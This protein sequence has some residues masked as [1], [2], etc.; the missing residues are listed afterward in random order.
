ML[1]SQNELAKILG[2]GQSAIRTLVRMGK[3]PHNDA[4]PADGNAACFSRDRIVEWIRAGP[5]LEANDNDIDKLR[6]S[7]WAAHPGSM[8]A[9]KEFGKR[10]A[11]KK[12]PKLYY[13]FK[14][15]NKK[16]GHMWYVMY[17]DRGKLVPSK[18]STGTSDKKAAEVFAIESREPLLAAYYARKGRKPADMYRL[19]EGYY[20]EGSELL[21]ADANRGRTLCDKRRRQCLN[22]VKKKFVPFIKKNGAR[23]IEDINAAMLNRFQDHLL[24]TLAPKS[25][26][27]HASAVRVMFK[28]L[29]AT[30]YADSNPFAGLPAIKKGEGK[31]TGCYEV[32][33]LK[34]AFGG[35]W[36]NPAHRILC[37]LIYS[38]GM[39]NGEIN[40][41]RL[42][43]LVEIGGETF[44]D[45]PK[46]K[47]PSGERKVPLHPFARER[48]V[49]YAGGRDLVF[50]QVGKTFEKLC[51]A[52]NAALGERLGYTREML[53]A[54]NIRFYSGRHFWKTMMSSENL[55]ESA[56]KLLMG[57]KVSGDI[58]NTYNHLDKV[59]AEK[60][61][62][63]AREAFAVLDRCLFG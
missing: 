56:E 27:D 53:K 49:G 1:L 61:A 15:E 63:V 36:D 18:W 24:K 3:I 43:D 51:S 19:F 48:L 10:F 17:S 28:R 55:G 21:E 41:L 9:I 39:R 59:G 11:G 13:L 38:T 23:A 35:E 57:H 5:D 37:L 16:H 30:G 52:A 2:V 8:E 44:I 45:I 47:T 62:K 46:S 32:G 60:L 26:N 42:G 12:P 58:A 50:P 40:R 14:R 33:R 25:V 22:T 7:L 29:V 54:E 20:E 4:L 6:E 34:G 31:I